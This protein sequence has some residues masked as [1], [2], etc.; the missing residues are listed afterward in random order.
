MQQLHCDKY[1]LCITCTVLS[2]ACQTFKSSKSVESLQK[3]DFDFNTLTKTLKA[4]KWILCLTLHFGGLAVDDQ[5][6][7]YNCKSITDRGLIKA[8]RISNS[9]CTCKI[10]LLKNKSTRLAL[11]HNHKPTVPSNNIFFLLW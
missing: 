4:T 8:S 10:K 7:I 3:I 5:V 2:G 1:L 9:S 11:S 6:K